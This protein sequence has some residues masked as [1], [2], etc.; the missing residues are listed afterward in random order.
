MSTSGPR[1]GLKIHAPLWWCCMASSC[2][3]V[4]PPRP[5][6]PARMIL[7]QDFLPGAVNPCIALI[8]EGRGSCRLYWLGSGDR[9]TM[10]VHR[11]WDICVPS[12]VSVVIR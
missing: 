8:L 11:R 7:L 1:R 12:T 5:Y 4:S 9:G 6:R 2:L 3:D 10:G